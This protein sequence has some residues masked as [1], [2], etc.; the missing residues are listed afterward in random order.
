[1]LEKEA[2]KRKE[3]TAKRE[4]E[5]KK[6]REEREAKTALAWIHAHTAMAE[7]AIHKPSTL[8][9]VIV[10]TLAIKAASPP[11]GQRVIPI[12]DPAGTRLGEVTLTRKESNNWGLFSELYETVQSNISAAKGRVLYDGKKKVRENGVIRDGDQPKT[13][14]VGGP[15]TPSAVTET[16]KAAVSAVAQATNVAEQAIEKA[17]HNPNQ[18]N[19]VRAVLAAEAATM[20]ADNLTAIANQSGNLTAQNMAD[21][22]TKEAKILVKTAEKIAGRTPPPSANTV[23]TAVRSLFPTPQTAP[24]AAVDAAVANVVKAGEDAVAAVQRADASPTPENKE[25]AKAAVQSAARQVARLHATAS[26]DGNREALEVAEAMENGVR[27]LQTEIDELGIANKEKSK[28]SSPSLANLLTSNPGF[29]GQGGASR[30]NRHKR[31][32]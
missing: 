17:A 16:T 20:V 1:M 15:L 28:S 26:A 10:E 11:A 31:Y 24:T 25:G 12:V 7:A 29:F 23:A 3:V 22:A 13:I 5:K 4:A 14:T 27:A 19:A 21:A 18:V 6:K 8:A 32:M 2:A 9:A 30:Q